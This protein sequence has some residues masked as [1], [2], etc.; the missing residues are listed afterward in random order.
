MSELMDALQR[1]MDQK[2]KALEELAAARYVLG[3]IYE[4]TGKVG[5]ADYWLGQ[6]KNLVVDCPKVF[7]FCKDDEE[8]E[9]E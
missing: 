8:G 3:R 2:A 1:Q 9:K 4:I 5:A 6:I 7:E